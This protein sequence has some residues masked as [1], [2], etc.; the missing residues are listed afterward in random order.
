MKTVSKEDDRIKEPA[1]SQGER[2]QTHVFQKEGRKLK[3]FFALAENTRTKFLMPRQTFSTA[4]SLPLF[5][6]HFF[7]ISSKI[8]DNCENK[9][10][11]K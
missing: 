10:Q 7:Q 8:I 9:N 1:R 6:I 2:K 5:V 11:E 4:F 3:M